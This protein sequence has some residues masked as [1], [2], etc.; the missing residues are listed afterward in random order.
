[1]F[2]DYQDLREGEL[3]INKNDTWNKKKTKKQFKVT[4]IESVQ[5]V[6]CL[7]FG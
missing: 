3:K 5:V 4:F 7:R 6:F 1:M 2:E